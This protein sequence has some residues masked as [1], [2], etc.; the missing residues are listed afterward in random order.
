MSVSPGSYGCGA[1]L[2]G[3]SSTLKLRTDSVSETL[4]NFHP[5]TWLSAQEDFTEFC[6]SRGFKTC[7]ILFK[8]TVLK[9]VITVRY[10]ITAMQNVVIMHLPEGSQ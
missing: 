2:S 1:L 9:Q 10:S 6:R 3:M 4:E 8:L 7:D 5:S